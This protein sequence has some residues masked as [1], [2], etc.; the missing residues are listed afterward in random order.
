MSEENTNN[1][2]LVTYHR[3]DYVGFITLNRPEKRN[4]MN[5]ALWEALDDAIAKADAD[6]EAR[7]ILLR[8]EGKSFCS[9]LQ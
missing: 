2:S 6:K 4:A 8:G 7:V 5:L 3:E 1:A 9:G